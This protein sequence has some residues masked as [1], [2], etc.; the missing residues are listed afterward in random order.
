MAGFAVS[1]IPFPYPLHPP[2]T[3]H[4]GEQIASQVRAAAGVSPGRGLES[5]VPRQRHTKELREFTLSHRT[6]RLAQSG[7]RLRNGAT[8]DD[9]SINFG[10]NSGVICRS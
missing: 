9:P 4:P 8:R 1:I 10:Y 7:V 6:S 3:T 2:F 5:K